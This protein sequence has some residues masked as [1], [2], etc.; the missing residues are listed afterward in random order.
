MDERIML[1]RT[2]SGNPLDRAVRARLAR[3]PH[4]VAEL[5]RVQQAVAPHQ[6]LDALLP[7]QVLVQSVDQL[8]E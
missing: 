3:L 5:P 2:V 8:G 6:H 4:P 1:T 7:H